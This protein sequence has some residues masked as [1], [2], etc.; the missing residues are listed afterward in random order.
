MNFVSFLAAINIFFEFEIDVVVSVVLTIEELLFPNPSGSQLESAF[1]Q[2]T[3]S[4]KLF[5]SL[6]MGL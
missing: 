4:L 5:V 1:C 2:A 6:V 3:L